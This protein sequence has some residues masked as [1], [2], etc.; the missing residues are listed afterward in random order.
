LSKSAVFSVII[1]RLTFL[2]LRVNPAGKDQEIEL[3]GLK[4]EIHG[5]SGD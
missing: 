2:T 5:I 4:K 1:A 3:P